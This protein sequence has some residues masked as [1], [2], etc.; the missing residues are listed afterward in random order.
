ML[1]VSIENTDSIFHVSIHVSWIAIAKL[2]FP[3]KSI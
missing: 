2:N 3:M 1:Y